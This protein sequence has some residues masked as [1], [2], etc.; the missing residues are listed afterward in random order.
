MSTKKNVA[1]DLGFGTQIGDKQQRMLNRDGSFNVIRKGQSF[2]DTFN[3]YHALITMGWGKFILL[4]SLFYIAVNLVFAFVFYF[5]G[6]ENL[7]GASGHTTLEKF[8]DA[9]FFSAQ[10]VTTLGY[11]RIS[12]IGFWA[13]FAAAIESIV[14]LMSFAIITGLLYGRF[15]RPKARI[16]QSEKALISPYRDTNALMFRIINGKVNQLIEVEVQVVVALRV[17]E[18]GVPIR[19]FSA[20]DLERSK[21]SLFPTNWTIVHPIDEKSPLYNMTGEEM[22]EL[23]AEF[24]IMLKGFD[25]SFSQTVYWRSSFKHS[26]IVWGAKFV[27]ILSNQ[28][29]GAITIDMERFHHFDIVPLNSKLQVNQKEKIVPN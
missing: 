28:S 21:I 27:T 9:F 15:S 23:D 16:I 13:S 22:K 12:P 29:D 7:A 5:I 1:D 3:T 14:G 20:L 10:T 11:G 24:S 6:M 18:K 17:M 8:F 26:D 4:V 25:D 2:W 19:R